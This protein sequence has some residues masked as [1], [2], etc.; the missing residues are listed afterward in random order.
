MITLGFT[1]SYSDAVTVDTTFPL[2]NGQPFAST[3]IYVGVAGDIVWKNPLG[4]LNWLPGAAVGYHP[5][6]AIEIVSSGT[7]NGNMRTTTASSMAYLA[8]GNY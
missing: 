2:F 1:G 7:V 8:S 3:Y 4:V 5:I 6:S